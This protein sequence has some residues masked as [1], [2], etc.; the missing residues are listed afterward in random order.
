MKCAILQAVYVAVGALAFACAGSFTLT[1]SSPL[2]Q[3]ASLRGTA[4]RLICEVLWPE[5]SLSCT[6]KQSEQVHNEPSHA[7][8]SY[9][10]S[11]A[12][13]PT[14]KTSRLRPLG[15]HLHSQ[16]SLMSHAERVSCLKRFPN[17]SY[18]LT[19]P[20][21]AVAIAILSRFSYAGVCRL[22]LS[23]LSQLTKIG[24]KRGFLQAATGALKISNSQKAHGT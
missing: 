22:F 19:F 14:L 9:S 2:A 3:T 6:T 15:D 1:S 20:L 16:M 12:Q 5:C 8:H 17:A 4:A 24:K 21:A 10:T 7:S 13:L 18:F 11:P 23:S